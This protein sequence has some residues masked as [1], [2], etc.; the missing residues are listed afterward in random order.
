ML[1]DDDCLR[2]YTMISFV[3]GIISMGYYYV[4]GFE[5]RIKTS[6]RNG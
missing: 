3:L 4:G 2:Y 6:K 1:N 5:G